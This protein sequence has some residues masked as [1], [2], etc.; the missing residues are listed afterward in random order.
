MPRPKDINLYLTFNGSRRKAAVASTSYVD[1]GSDA[2]S[3]TGSVSTRSSREGIT[4]PKNWER[5]ITKHEIRT[6]Y[7]RLSPAKTVEI[8]DAL[9]VRLG[10][11]K[12]PTTWAGYAT[13]VNGFKQFLAKNPQVEAETLAIKICFFL[14]Y[15]MSTPTVRKKPLGPQSAFVYLK[16]LRA[17]HRRSISD[18]ADYL[19]LLEFSRALVRQGALRH[20][21]TKPLEPEELQKLLRMRLPPPVRIGI[22]ILWITCSRC[23]DLQRLTVLDFVHVQG[24]IWDFQFEGHKGSNFRVVTRTELD[25]ETHNELVEMLHQQADQKIPFAD[26]DAP[27]VA[28]WLRKVNPALSGHSPKKGGLVFL[29]RQGSSLDTIRVMAKHESIHQTKAYL[30]PGEFAAAMGT[31]HAS[32]SLNQVIP[33][34]S[35]IGGN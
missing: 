18:E 5:N 35:P 3:E 23:S 13:V 2:T 32:Q 26:L 6:K 33:Q 19:I 27:T 29:L 7:T 16:K 30:P 24:G 8:L 17:L 20:Q 15:K 31:T 25:P 34:R 11:S 10:E 21:G 1:T 28:R 14:E 12:A 4:I 9:E 22:K